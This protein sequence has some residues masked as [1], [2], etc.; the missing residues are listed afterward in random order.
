MKN[1]ISLFIFL[2]SF[3]ALASPRQ[4]TADQLL[5]NYA[6]NPLTLSAPVLG[7]AYS[8]VLPMAQGSSGQ[9]MVNDGA[10]NFSWA[11]IITSLTSDVSAS[12]SGAVAATVNSVGGSTASAVHTAELLANGAT[13][14][15]TPSTIVKR[16]GS[17]NFA[18]GTI[19][20]AL[21]GNAT[22]VT[23]VVAAANGGTG[24][25]TYTAGDTLYASG[26]SAISK[27]AVGSSTQT[28]H[29]GATPSWSAVSLTADVSGTLPVANGGTGTTTSTGSGSTVLS[30][31][32]A[33]VTPNLGTPSSA[34]LTNATALPLTTG[35]TGTLGVANGGTGTTT[36]TGSGSTVLS[37]SP[38]L[39]TPALGTPSAAVLTNATGLPLPGGVTG[40]LSVARGGTNSSTALNNNRV[41]TSSG[42]ALV[43][44]SAITAN[45][46]LASDT[47]GLPVA[48]AT[49]D[50]QLG[51]L[52]TTTSDVQTQ[53]N[54]KT[55]NPMTT[56][57]DV[58]YG[59]TAGVPTRL[60]ASTSV[61][62]FHSGTT[63]SWSPVSLTADVTGALPIANGGT[64]QT[65][66]SAAFNSLA[67]TSAKGDLIVNNGTGNTA[68]TVGTNDH[69]LHANSAAGNGVDWS[70]VG[71]TTGVTGTL[72]VANG[73]TGTTTSTGS[74]NTVLST[75]P[76]LVTPALGT[77]SAAVLTNATGLPL[78]TG[79]TGTLGVT[80]GG[81]GTTTSTGSGNTV[82]STSP[83]LVTP[84]L[85]TP[86]SATLTNATGLP[87]TTGVTGTLPVANGGTGMTSVTTSPTATSFAG[88]DA[89]KNL[90]ANSLL[91]GYTTTVTAAGTTTLTVTSTQQQYF[92][93]TTTQTVAL[94]VVSTL[95]LG[96]SY[97]V[98]NNS[99]GIVTVQSSGGNTVQ[100]M[101][102]SSYAT[103]TVV[104]TTGTTAAS[105]NV[106]YASSAAGTVTSV[107]LTVPTFLSISGSPVTTSGTLAV[108]LSGT[109]LPVVNGGTGTTTSTGTGNA[110]LST[111]PT[112]VTP[113]LGTPT[114][115]T[116][117][118]ATGLPLTTGVTGTLPLANGGTNATTKAGAFDS[119]SPMTT[120]GDVIYGGT[121]G[122]GTRL[123]PGTSAQVL[124]SGT[125]PSWSAVSLTGDVSGT[126]PTGNGGT[127][128]STWTAAS[129]PYL[130]STTAFSEDNAN[131]S[132]DGTNH[133]VVLGPSAG[134]TDA[135][136]AYQ[137][138]GGGIVSKAGAAFGSMGGLAQL[139]LYANAY[140]TATATRYASTAAGSA[141]YTLLN[142]K[143][144]AAGGTKVVT[145]LA[146]TG[147][148]T[149][150]NTV[151]SSTEAFSVT[152][153]GTG[154]FAS[155]ISASASTNGIAVE[156]A[157]SSPV[158][159]DTQNVYSFS[160]VSV[161]PSA[162]TNTAN[163]S[164]STVQG[165][166][167]G[168]IV[169]VSGQI[170]AVDITGTA[171]GSWTVRVTMPI[172]TASSSIAKTAG[173]AVCFGSSDNTVF[174]ASIQNEQAGA[175]R[176]EFEGKT[177]KITGTA[178][179][180]SCSYTY[181][182]QLE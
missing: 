129:I 143:A 77:P 62:L 5:L 87:L 167:V 59:G 70:Q 131:F 93:G 181:T 84:V 149:A 136:G 120:A 13:S 82:L 76:T 110:V 6:G 50:T 80:N 98:I 26:A 7:S 137:M 40:T 109:A 117:T 32:P 3:I 69:F 172:T 37:T 174:T 150:D 15:N 54:G 176:A 48:S 148:S 139:D 78:T 12:G 71:L 115:A 67:P 114:S 43:E 57:G 17:G 105:W 19:T 35:V 55:S 171:G 147:A 140:D 156:A 53:I 41:I 133:K 122:T 170:T 23:G 92:T 163:I 102:A 144:A 33:L 107:A 97:L 63:P 141:G 119:L 58:I 112:L 180:L 29:S 145:V 118:N 124:H 60:A 72:P 39:V 61:Q 135:S 113:V 158:K 65:G 104:L 52:S 91:S 127:N 178:T 10:G 175:F 8:L 47:N 162:G 30:T 161:T 153:A 103:F 94:P 73:G 25:S 64:G 75:S 154:L 157:R 99:S 20:A 128:K 116:L 111:S 16:D 36:S 1:I 173:T 11:S 106:E 28:L 134:L 168:N 123:A 86:T 100:A 38:T 166:R 88:W 142:L 44:A 130:S 179:G 81:T 22:N 46:A 56:A 164:A 96:Q 79:V 49:T 151:G 68:L 18:A 9:C 126:L 146:G 34:V 138:I 125:T 89:S 42:G 182:Y 14:A 24:Q 85:G 2:Y 169:T 27:L 51:Y 159:G 160:G 90:S 121:S 177:T 66:A 31:S 74:G 4:L 152:A 21:T 108:T 95:V 155:V 83:T 165:M 132:W 45:H 101:G